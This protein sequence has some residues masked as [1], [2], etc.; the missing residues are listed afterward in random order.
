MK[1][2]ALAMKGR[3]P[4]EPA[5]ES[6]GAV[7]TGVLFFVGAQRRRPTSSPRHAAI[8]FSLRRC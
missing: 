5:G 6:E 3:W 8:L 2:A 4:E 1:D 7:D